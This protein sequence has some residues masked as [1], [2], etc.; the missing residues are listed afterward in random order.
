MISAISLMRRRADIRLDAFRRHW[1]GVHGP[2]VCGFPGLRGYVQ[3]H[4]IHAAPTNAPA[5]RFGIDGFPIL[6]FD[7]DA[8]RVRAHA[9]PEMAACNVDSRGFIGAVSRVIAEPRV[10]VAPAAGARFGLIML[11]PGAVPDDA[12]LHRYAETAL[13]LPGLAGLV[14]HQVREQGPAPNST[15][16]HLPVGVAGLAEVRFATRAAVAAEEIGAACFLAEAHDLAPLAP[17]APSA[18]PSSRNH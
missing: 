15:V 17:V 14:L 7:D 12:R 5:R 3:W 8:A 4:V 18:A 1:I 11:F 2:L 13:R 10:L 16:P 6:W 9:S